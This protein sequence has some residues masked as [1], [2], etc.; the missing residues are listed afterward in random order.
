MRT[1]AFKLLIS[2]C[3]VSIQ[4][5]TFSSAFAK[6]GGS[7]DGGG[8]DAYELRVSDIRSDI[9]SW[10]KKGG[11][12][13]LVLKN[14]EYTEYS[15]KMSEILQPQAVVVGF[16]DNDDS[17]NDELVV[18]TNGTSRPCR[19]FISKKDSKSHILCN[20]SKFK[21]SSES[22]QYKII[23]HEYAGLVNLENSDEDNS[24]SDQIPEFLTEQ[25]VLKLAV[26]KQVIDGEY[27]VP[28]ISITKSRY[29][30]NDSFEVTLAVNSAKDVV[31]VVLGGGDGEGSWRLEDCQTA[32]P[33]LAFSEGKLE[34][35]FVLNKLNCGRSFRYIAFSNIS[36]EYTDGTIK[37]MKYQRLD[38]GLKESFVQPKNLQLKMKILSEKTESFVP[39]YYKKSVQRKNRSLQFTYKVTAEDMAEYKG[40]VFGDGEEFLSNDPVK[41]AD[42]INS[43]EIIVNVVHEEKYSKEMSCL[44][45]NGYTFVFCRHVEVVKKGQFQLTPV[46]GF[47][48]RISLIKKG[49]FTETE[50][51]IIK[52]L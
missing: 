17:S 30:G 38:Y 10:I 5:L 52:E 15:L 13:G 47:I 50:T 24:I 1:K 7:M 42:V 32:M 2:T 22:E 3:L 51:L 27:S 29:I 34:Q 35:T 11:P 4:L 6:S 46:W 16:V 28:V 36:V 33:T 26:K 45:I 12:K 8:G 25:S 31:Q 48:S 23:H 43:K 40:V 9:L 37:L 44:D 18:N 21:K 49:D 20:I 19:G 14:I 41:L 39:E